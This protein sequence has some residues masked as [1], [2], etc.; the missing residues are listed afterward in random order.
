MRL[1]LTLLA[2]TSIAGCGPRRPDDLVELRLSGIPKDSWRL[3][4]LARPE[5]GLRQLGYY[6]THDYFGTWSLSFHSSGGPGSGSGLTTCRWLE[7][8]RYGVLIRD[9][10]RRWFVWWIDSAAVRTAPETGERG[11]PV[12][13]LRL[14]NA[15]ATE[16]MPTD[17]LPY[18]GIEWGLPRPTWRVLRE[19]VP[20]SRNRDRITAGQLTSYWQR[21]DLHL[22]RARAAVGAEDLAS[23][24]SECAR[25]IDAIENILLDYEEWLPT[26]GAAL[27]AAFRTFLEIDDAASRGEFAAVTRGI[28]SLADAL[29]QLKGAPQ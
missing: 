5:A 25:I 14:E 10:R 4:L 24:S 27:E 7:A 29:S 11:Q 21:W 8:P 16:P 13:L 9:T 17:V 18:L 6:Q 20:E 28:Q 23:A 12:Y 1:A 3:I 2:L 22:S 15:S 26:E 19:G